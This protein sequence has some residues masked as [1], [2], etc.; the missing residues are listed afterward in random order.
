[1]SNI[2]V[3]NPG[4]LPAFAKKAEMSAVA[5]ALMGSNGQSGKRISIK[6]GVFRL[7]ADGKEVAAVEERYLDVVVVNAAPKVSRTY[8]EGTYTEG[9]AVPPTC[10]SQDG[11]V[12]DKSLKAPQAPS[13][14]ACPQN[15]KGSGQGDSRACRFSQRLAVVLA[16]DM[17]GDVMQL[18]L[19]AT[20]IFG[21]ADGE[22]RPLQEHSRWLVAQGIDPTMLITRMKFDTK[23]PVPKLFFKPMRWLT[24]DEFAITQEKGVSKEAIAAITMTVSQQDGVTAA[25]P[26]P[27]PGTPPT[28]AKAK[29]APAPEADEEDEAPAPAPKA[30]VKAAPAPAPEQ[31][32]DEAPAPKPKAKA[33]AAPLPPEEDD[34]EPAV[35]AAPV[36]AKATVAPAAGLAKT[37]ADWDDE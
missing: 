19:A 16:N 36:K 31:D 14:A 5:K 34:D 27:F 28:K 3:F 20:S 21:K 15:A 32:E 25:A 11:D 4:Q 12:P 10:W 23:A 37:L 30:K 6:G 9:A 17:E 18:S 29:A 33:K 26:A 24:E 1:M 8:Y 13:C 2:Q 22:N 7:I 35:K